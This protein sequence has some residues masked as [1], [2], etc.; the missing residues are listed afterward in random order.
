M[1]VSMSVRLT[2]RTIYRIP[3]E[4]LGEK[5]WEEAKYRYEEAVKKAS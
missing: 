4:H 3:L 5:E 2:D 1:S